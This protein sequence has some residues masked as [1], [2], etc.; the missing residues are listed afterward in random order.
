MKTGDEGYNV[1]ID[2][3]DPVTHDAH[4]TAVIKH[5][6]TFLREKDLVPISTISNTI[7]PKALYESFGSPAFYDKYH[8]GF[9]DYGDQD[10]GRY[11][12]R[13]TRHRT[14]EGET[15]NPLQEL[16]QKMRERVNSDQQYKAVYELA[17]YDPLQDRRYLRGGQCLSFLSFKHHP[18]RGVIL[19][20]VYRNQTYVTRCLGN[21]I[22]L[23]RLQQFVAK[24]SGID[25]AGPLTCIST[26]AQLDKGKGW[27]ISDARKLVTDARALLKG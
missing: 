21:L 27:T 6:D 14:L 2:V 7:F 8:E 26:H 5:V 3:D 9:E 15:Y 17:I 23:G 18:T 25:R 16:I 12:E 13:M 1:I 10:W 4:D 11:F 24:E 22:G 20:A 19:T